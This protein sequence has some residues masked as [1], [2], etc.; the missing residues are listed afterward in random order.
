ME[1]ARSP[2]ETFESAPLRVGLRVDDHG[3]V[4]VEQASQETRCAELFVVTLNAERFLVGDRFAQLFLFFFVFKGGERLGSVSYGSD[5]KVERA[6]TAKSKRMY[7]EKVYMRIC[8]MW[9]MDGQKIHTKQA[10]RV[11]FGLL[12][13]T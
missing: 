3:Q 2:R 12:D 10:A 9:L 4:V 8:I 11:R 5:I 7:T 1:F 6:L 13:L